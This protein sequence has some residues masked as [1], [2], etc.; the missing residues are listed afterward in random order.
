MYVKV[1][2][3]MWL[4]GIHVV[5]LYLVLTTAILLVGLCIHTQRELGIK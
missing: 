4:Q 2:G 5:C 3:H 1:K